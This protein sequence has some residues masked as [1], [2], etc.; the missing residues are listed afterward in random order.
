[1]PVFMPES[2]ALAEAL[3]SADAKE[4]SRPSLESEQHA[5]AVFDARRHQ[6]PS[7]RLGVWFAWGG[8]DCWLYAF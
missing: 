6:R 2:A 3:S 1:M 4:A 8:Y 5:F 7:D